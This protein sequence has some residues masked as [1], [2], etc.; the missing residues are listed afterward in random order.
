MK[1]T[2]TMSAKVEEYLRFRRGLGYR[3]KIEGQMLQNFGCF[4]D[5]SGHRGPLTVELA[6]RWA[7][8]AEGCDRLYW[9]RRL[10]VVRCFARHL[11]VAEPRT[12]IPGR[13]L[14]G[15]AH[16]RTVPHIYTAH[17]LTA[18]LAAARRLSSADG[19]RPRTYVTLIGLLACTG[20]RISEALR[21]A[22]VDVDFGR[23]VLKIRETKFRKTR[24]VPL[25]PTAV[26]A[27][28]AYANKRSRLLRVAT[29]DRFF[30][31]HQGGNLPRSLS[32]HSAL[33]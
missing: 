6:L 11:A 8:S 26:A 31:S 21:L 20:L 24:F 13:R 2:T 19:L 25:H 29:S 4:A 14:L 28:R 15:P 9:A 23:G 27:L 17:E 18:L 32:R 10:E 5:A 33:F 3:L 7:Q 1:R 16:R 30:L 12:E 22:Q